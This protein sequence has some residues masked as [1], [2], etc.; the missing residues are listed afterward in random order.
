MV[1]VY[2]VIAARSE[3][4]EEEL[5][6]LVKRVEPS[7]V[8][9]RTWRLPE[10]SWWYGSGFFVNEWGDVVTNAHVVE[11]SSYTSITT[12]GGMIFRVQRIL[13]TD[14]EADLAILSANISPEVIHPL[15]LC[16]ELPSVGEDIL[17]V[18]SAPLEEPDVLTGVVTAVHRIPGMAGHV[19]VKASACAGWSGSAVLNTRGQ[20]LGVLVAG[21]DG[22][23]PWFHAVPTEEV[24][25]LQGVAGLDFFGAQERP[26]DTSFS[27]AKDLYVGARLCGMDGDRRRACTYYK[28]AIE[29]DPEFYYAYVMASGTYSGLG[30]Y[31]DAAGMLER[32]ALL[33]PG[34]PSLYKELAEAYEELGLLEEAIDCYQL[35]LRLDTGD[36]LARMSLGLVYTVQRTHSLA[37]EV[38]KEGIRLFPECSVFYIGLG[39]IYSDQGRYEDAIAAFREAVRVDP[40]FSLAYEFLGDALKDLGSVVEATAEY[41]R[42]ARLDPTNGSTHSDL[43]KCHLELGNL[44]RAV[45]KYWILMSFGEEDKKSLA[46]MIFGGLPELD[47]E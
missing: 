36:L 47:E 5:E 31:E 21:R 33:D 34:N 2:C 38:F 29:K 41:E 35:A 6:W 8:R 18:G 39:M 20:L 24:S 1:L 25:R 32:A 45:E 14:E 44:W 46:K 42:A 11:N 16:S 26:L 43:G 4:P 22:V 37:T 28:L 15:E 27:T 23:D 13:G 10:R 17:L 40:E 30:E 12:R 19:G 9:I 3:I 7:V